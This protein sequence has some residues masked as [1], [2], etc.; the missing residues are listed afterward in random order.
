MK[1][2]S[3]LFLAWI[4]LSLML[5]MRFGGAAAATLPTPIPQASQTP[6]P[7]VAAT[8]T[9]PPLLVNGQMIDMERGF[10]VF[11]SGDAFKLSPGV[12]IVDNSTGAAPAYPIEPGLYAVATMDWYTGQVTMIKVSHRP[13][14]EGTPAAKIPHM[15][16]AE[17]SSP[18]PNP[19]L[20]PPSRVYSSQLSKSVAVEITAEVPPD[21]PFS[22]DVYMTTD[23]S[24]W[25]PLAIK[26]E[27]VDGRHFRI[28]IDWPGGTELHYLFTR[29]GWRSVE[30]DRAGLQR[31]PRLLFV[32]GG[33]SMTV[34]VTVQR[35]A[36][37]P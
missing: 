5:A 17:A 16:A 28:E 10:I 3:Y 12:K 9:P 23:T 1:A 34:N 6:P 27:R 14:P 29:G 19:D 13:L 7:D 32:P 31:P 18:R 24:G 8:P 37:L 36:D 25:N 22:D 15:Y 33:D 30:R 21:T 4:A 35:W 2:A 11:A 20:V 26:M